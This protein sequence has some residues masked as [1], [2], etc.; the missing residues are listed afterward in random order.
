MKKTMNMNRRELR[1]KILQELPT[2]F[3]NTDI[4]SFHEEF[5]KGNND[6]VDI[7]IALMQ[8]NGGHLTV[9]LLNVYNIY[10]KTGDESVVKSFCEELSQKYTCT[11]SVSVKELQNKISKT[12][13]FESICCVVLNTRSNQS[14][15]QNSIHEERGPFSIVLKQ[16]AID[17]SGHVMMVEIHPEEIE[18]DEELRMMD[19]HTLIEK[20]ISN[21]ASHFHVEVK[22]MAQVVANNTVS[23]LL[24]NGLIPETQDL[25][26]VNFD[27]I[28]RKLEEELPRIYSLNNG[29]PF[30]AVSMFYPGFLSNFCKMVNANKLTIIPRT[31]DE[32]FI[33]VDNS[34]DIKG[35]IET[36]DATWELNKENQLSEEVF[37]YDASLDT[38]I[39][40]S[41]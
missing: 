13:L 12:A 19:K 36:I 34:E 33:Q 11:I 17:S 25:C 21:T 8:E 28:V 41:N 1:H 27:K 22:S 31:I 6:T 3:M 32:I 16:F 30:G 5:V 18:A 7:G 4:V 23:Q 10:E 26:Q 15:L 38:I 39:F 29:T 35:V 24:D 14:L 2:Y 20:A 37:S 9:M 40:N